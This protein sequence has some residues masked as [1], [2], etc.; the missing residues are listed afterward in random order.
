[1]MVVLGSS[2]NC[3]AAVSSSSS[4]SRNIA[5]DGWQAWDVR[6]LLIASR[7]LLPLYRRGALRG[8]LFRPMTT[9]RATTA[10]T[11]RTACTA[12]PPPAYR[13]RAF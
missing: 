12:P 6:E 10:S 2:P 1:M 13:F 7:S 11:D 5:G 9:F 4:W 8:H 3:Q